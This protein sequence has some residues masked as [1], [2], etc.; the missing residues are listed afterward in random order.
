VRCEL[1]PIKES[2]DRIIKIERLKQEDAPREGHRIAR[3]TMI[4]P[5]RLVESSFKCG[6]RVTLLTSARAGAGHRP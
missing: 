6:L 5:L 2:K 3:L 4:L 1:G